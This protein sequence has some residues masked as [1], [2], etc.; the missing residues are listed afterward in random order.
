MKNGTIT[1]GSDTFTIA[2]WKMSQHFSIFNTKLLYIAYVSLLL[3]PDRANYIQ[4]LWKEMMK[5]FILEKYLRLSI[6][7]SIFLI[8][9]SLNLASVM[10]IKKNDGTASAVVDMYNA[11]PNSLNVFAP[12]TRNAVNIMRVMRNMTRI[13]VFLKLNDFSSPK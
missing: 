1:H 9:L 3:I 8:V 13:I 12:K 7:I 5:F 11:L 2:K 10:K 4:F 6:V